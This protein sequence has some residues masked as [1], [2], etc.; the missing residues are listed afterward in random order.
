M[1]SPVTV[2]TNSPGTRGRIIALALLAATATGIASFPLIKQAQAIQ[3]VQ[4]T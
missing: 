2:N 4:T 3:T 1:K